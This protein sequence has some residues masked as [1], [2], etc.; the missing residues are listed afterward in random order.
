VYCCEISDAGSIVFRA[1]GHCGTFQRLGFHKFRFSNLGAREIG[2][3]EIRFTKIGAEKF[4][5][6]QLGSAKI[7]SNQV[8]DVKI[9]AT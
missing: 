9:S 1:I 4:G 2:Q 8:A 5:T 6:A 7:R 3:A